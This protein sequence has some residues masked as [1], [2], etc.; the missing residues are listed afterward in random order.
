[1]STLERAATPRPASDRMP[2]R[3]ARARFLAVPLRFKLL[4]AN[5]LI[6][7]AALAALAF[8]DRL[9]GGTLTPATV[10]VGALVLTSVVNVLLVS[11]A[12]QPLSE[13]ERTASRIWHGDLQARVP[14]SPLADQELQRV[15][16]TLN[17]L[18]DGL[19][20]DRARMRQLA[21]QVISAQDQ[22]RSRVAR[23]LHDSTAQT[24]TAAMLQ[25]GALV[26]MQPP[27][28][29]AQLET[30]RSLVAAALEEVRSLAHTIYPRVLDDLGLPA[31]LEW[32]ARQTRDSSALGVVVEAEVRADAVPPAAA[33]VLYR[34]AQEALRNVVLHAEARSVQLTLTLH[35][36]VAMLVVEDDGRGFVVDEAEKRRPGMGLFAMRERASLVNGR[37]AIASTPGSG[38]RI[39]AEVPVAPR[40]A[41]LREQ[42]GTA[43][44]REGA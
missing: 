4:G 38:T 12:L 5:A 25:I 34:V 20:S 37:V 26:R 33:A 32:L 40:V 31:A 8:G 2:R 3:G 16:R 30:L 22:E 21:S 7:G 17:L 39:T 11:A 1:M 13:L 44:A 24:L 42:V 27:E 43:P 35:D 18:L 10:L 29:A 28:H 36:D 19:T 41:P 9:A 6:V 14:T 15:G 23:E